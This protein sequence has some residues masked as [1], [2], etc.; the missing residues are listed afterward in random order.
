MAIAAFF[1][2]IEW[3]TEPTFTTPD[4]TLAMYV[5]QGHP[6]LENEGE[7]L[8]GA[9]YVKGKSVVLRRTVTLKVWQLQ[10]TENTDDQ[11]FGLYD[12]FMLNCSLYPFKRIADTD[13]PRV[14]RDASGAP[15]LLWTDGTLGL[16][17]WN[18]ELEAASLA[19]ASDGKNVFSVTLFSPTVEA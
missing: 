18:F 1:V 14:S 10:V 3:C 17:P 16:C 2:E 11:D 9:D 5:S 4:A 19:E 7:E 12:Q 8:I 15:Y 13:L 6:P